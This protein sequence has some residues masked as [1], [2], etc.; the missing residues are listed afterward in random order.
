MTLHRQQVQQELLGRPVGYEELSRAVALG[1]A[2]SFEV[3]LVPHTLSP[4]ESAEAERL[5]AR[6]Y[7]TD[8]WNA[9][10]PGRRDG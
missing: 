10:V 2:E 4:A 6:K 8:E 5:R 1:F 9:R 7:A 3:E